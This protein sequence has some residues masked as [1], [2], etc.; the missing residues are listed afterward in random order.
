ME[1]IWTDGDEGKG[2]EFLIQMRIQVVTYKYDCYL[3]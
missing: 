1:T 2:P 3:K